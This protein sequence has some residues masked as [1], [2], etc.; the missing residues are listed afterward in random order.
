MDIESSKFVLNILSG[1]QKK[2]HRKSQKSPSSGYTG[3]VTD[4]TNDYQSIYRLPTTDLMCVPGLKFKWFKFDILC[5][6]LRRKRKKICSIR[7]EMFDICHST[8]GNL[9]PLICCCGAT[10]LVV[11]TFVD[12]VER[13][14]KRQRISNFRTE[15]CVQ[16]FGWVMIFQRCC[17]K[18]NSI[19][20]FLP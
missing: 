10:F 14:N 4:K 7:I 15:E 8:K 1:H 9:L 11:S 5:V 16:H 20:Y 18:K 17:G 12:L 6:H 19:T 13:E 2:W 3:T